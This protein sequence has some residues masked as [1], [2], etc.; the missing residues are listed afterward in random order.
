MNESINNR[1]QG[2]NYNPSDT[3]EPIWDAEAKQSFINLIR[4][5]GG[6]EFDLHVTGKRVPPQRIQKADK[7]EGTYRIPMTPK[8]CSDFLA[9]ITA[10][11]PRQDDQIEWIQNKLAPFH[12]T[13]GSRFKGFG[14]KPE[15]SKPD[16]KS[17]MAEFEQIAIE[18]DR[19]QAPHLVL[20]VALA[21]KLS[22]ENLLA[23]K[24]D[25]SMTLFGYETFIT[26]KPDAPLYEFRKFEEDAA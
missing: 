20:N 5:P 26:I 14:K 3:R 24:P 9:E 23:E 22:D 7:Y 8:D 15:A 10:E 13:P 16:F 6:F 21:I 12:W 1:F 17:W 19:E 11:A 4:T 18:N 2:S 25:K